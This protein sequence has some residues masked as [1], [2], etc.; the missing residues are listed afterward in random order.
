MEDINLNIDFS[1]YSNVF[2]DSLEALEWLYNNKLPREARIY[3]SSPALLFSKNK[4]IVHVESFWNISRMKEFQSSIQNFSEEVYD[5]LALI[6]G[7]SHEESLCISQAAVQFHR[8]LF[9]A[10]CLTDDHLDKPFLFIRTHGF[11]GPSGKNMN[12]PWDR[13]LINNNRFKIV[14]YTLRNNKWS[15]LTT[16][17]V[18]IWNRI[19]IG[20]IETLIYRLFLKFADKVPDFYFKGDAFVVNENE[21]LIETAA[22]LAL[23][24]VRI[25][26]VK[27]VESCNESYNINNINIIKRKIYTTIRNRVKEWVYPDLVEI[28]VDIFFQDVEKKLQEFKRFKAQF[29]N[30]KNIPKKRKKVLLINAPGNIKGMA[31]TSICKKE[32]IPVVAFQHGVTH[33]I[34]ST[35]GEVSVGYETNFSDLC[36]LYNN[37]SK[38]VFNN[39]HFKRASNYVSGISARHIRMKRS[40]FNITDKEF[41][42]AYVSTNLYKGN[43][44]N[45]STWETDYKRALNEKKLITKVFKKLPHKVC[46]KPYPE[47]NRHYP[48]KDPILLEGHFQGNVKLFSKKV[49][50]R[51]LINKHRVLVTSVATSTVSWLIMSGKPVI[52][53]NRRN[54]S[55]LTENAHISFSKGLFLFDDDNKNFHD[56]L[57]N[58]L[59]L[60]IEDIEELWKQ[61]KD[62]RKEMINQ[63]FTSSCHKGAGKV[64]AKFILNKYYKSTV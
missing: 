60:P 7:M 58:F 30:L 53:I 56:K 16:N 31:V 26:E 29:Y 55:P 40:I 50:M 1:L 42:I 43:K 41:P 8:I 45:F 18:S 47:D 54:T 49:D 48:D 64:S 11:E 63:F 33:E 46:Y 36:V 21:L 35:H 61:K 62:A 57:R 51:Y 19:R 38:K 37:E 23:K 17:G 44:E 3:T 15:S 6:E 14:D 39:S 22:N 4:G 27:L 5:K 10:A 34:C 59:S 52:F 13:I 12:S 24:R 32:K 9:K 2:C 20:G 28:C 25:K